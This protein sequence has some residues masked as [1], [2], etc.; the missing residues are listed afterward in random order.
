MLKIRLQ[1]VGR[2]NDPSYRIVV[3]ESS[4]GPRNGKFVELLGSYAP[5]AG[6]ISIDGERVKHWLSVGAQA[7]DTVHNMLVNEK[8]IE[9]KKR[10]SLPK[11][12]PI[13]REDKE[14]AKAPAEPKVEEGGETKPDQEE[15]ATEEMA[16]EAEETTDTAVVDE[17][18][19]DK[20]KESN[21]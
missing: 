2:R 13:V 1:R 18:E 21:E 14:E 4:R 15:R 7:S 16:D 12:R 3:T 6:T 17:V 19:K 9:G 11:K 10:N 8:V 20:P 5:K